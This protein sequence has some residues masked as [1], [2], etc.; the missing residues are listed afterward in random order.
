MGQSI[1]KLSVIGFLVATLMSCNQ[2]PT[3]QTYFVDNELKPG[4]SQIDA[5]TSLINVD[6]IEMTD[7]QRE[8][9]KSV[10]KLNILVYTPTDSLEGIGAEIEKVNQILKNPKYEELIR[11]NTIDGKFSVKYIGEVDNVDEVI[12][13]GSSE[14]RGFVIARLLG[15]N[16][17]AGKIYSLRTVL[18]NA[19]FDNSNL[20]GLTDFFK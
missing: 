3:L 9:Y 7:E 4:Y 14:D 17:N 15:D 11:G 2:G 13:F 5:P 1:K 20:N 16:M 12:L 10:D 8:A 19:N 6:E 18:Q